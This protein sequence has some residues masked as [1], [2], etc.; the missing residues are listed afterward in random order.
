VLID[1]AIPWAVRWLMK[2][3]DQAERLLISE[4]YPG[5]DQLWW[6]DAHGKHTFELRTAYFYTHPQQAERD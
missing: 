2:I 5:P 4:M 3:A 6:T 1:L